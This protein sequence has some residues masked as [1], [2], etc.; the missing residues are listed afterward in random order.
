M[1]VASPPAAKVADVKILC[2]GRWEWSTTARWGEVFNPSN[3]RVIARVPLCTVAE[4]D[5]VVRAAA[6]AAR[7]RWRL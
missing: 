7:G 4:V 1:S 3:G 5:G 6:D 2:G